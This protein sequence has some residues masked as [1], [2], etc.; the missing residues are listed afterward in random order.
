MNFDDDITV[1]KVHIQTNGQI[2]DEGIG[3]CHIILT[4]S[5]YSFVLSWTK[6][7]SKQVGW[8]HIPLLSKLCQFI[9]DCNSVIAT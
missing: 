3:Q 6:T 1:A 4:T 9:V 2:D 5:M 7:K 8:L